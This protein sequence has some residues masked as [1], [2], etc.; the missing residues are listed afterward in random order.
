MSRNWSKITFDVCNL[1]WRPHRA[2]SFGFCSCFVV[3]QTFIDIKE[4]HHFSGIL[5]RYGIKLVD[6]QGVPEKAEPLRN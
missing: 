5:Q 3:F 6:I 4:I 1:P 2:V